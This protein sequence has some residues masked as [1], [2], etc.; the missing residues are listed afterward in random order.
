[1]N[2]SGRKLKNAMK[3]YADIWFEFCR[4]WKGH[5]GY[6]PVITDQPSL[7]TLKSRIG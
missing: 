2:Q 1:M 6:V 3:L 7:V 4:A 5:W